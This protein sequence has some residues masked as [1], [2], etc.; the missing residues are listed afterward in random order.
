MGLDDRDAAALDDIVKRNV[1]HLPAGR[2]VVIRLRSY[3]VIHSF[4][5]PAFRVK[6][7]LIPGFPTRLQFTPTRVGEYEL[8]CAELCGLNHF[9][10]RGQV[11]V[12]EPAA[13]E[14]WLV[15]QAKYTL[16][17]G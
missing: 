6:Q 1:L 10:M 11:K 14:A 4:F 15:E 16:G 7:D 12:V 9:Q 5:V 8:A 17:G 2:P 3:D 13:Y